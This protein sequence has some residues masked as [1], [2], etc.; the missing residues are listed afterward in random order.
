MQK[1]RRDDRSK[2]SNDVKHG[3]IQIFTQLEA[4]RECDYTLVYRL[5]NKQV[6]KV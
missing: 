2:E 4:V 5:L 3:Q 1:H 6:C